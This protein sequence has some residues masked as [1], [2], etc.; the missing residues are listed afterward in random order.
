MLILCYLLLQ[1]WLDYGSGLTVYP[2]CSLFSFLLLLAPKID[3][4][5]VYVFGECFLSCSIG[6]GTNEVNQ[7]QHYI[8]SPCCQGAFRHPDMPRIF[9]WICMRYRFPFPLIFILFSFPLVAPVP[10]FVLG[11]INR[12]NVARNTTELLYAEIKRENYNP[13]YNVFSG[14][15]LH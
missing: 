2:V 10:L 6:F 8:S 13:L 5:H 9:Q 12:F 1:L 4:I 14:S 7:A 3:Q 11:L 15:E